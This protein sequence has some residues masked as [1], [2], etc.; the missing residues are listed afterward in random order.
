MNTTTPTNNSAGNNWF[1]F[2]FG[3]VFNLMAHIDLSFIMDYILQAIAGG[4]I[5]LA[6]KIIGDILSPLWLKQKERVRNYARSRKIANRKK[7]RTH[8]N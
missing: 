2:L 6:F 1:A 8:E 7:K 5:C 4:I 3:A